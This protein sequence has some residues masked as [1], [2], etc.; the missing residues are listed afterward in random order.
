MP[1]R[2]WMR[3][4][5]KAVLA[6]QILGFCIFTAAFFLPACRDFGADAASADTFMG[7]ECA[8]TT[9]ALAVEPDTFDSPLFLAFMSGWIN[10]LVLGYLTTG[11]VPRLTKVHRPIAA[12]IL[13]C[14]LATWVFFA[15]A[16]FTPLIGHV[17]WIAGALLILT[18][19]AAGRG[20]LPASGSGP[21]QLHP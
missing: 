20:Q 15:V 9:A 4:S 3:V 5:R 8:R 17:L 12:L 11:I 18:P 7:W 21:Q 13:V 19:E 6:C 10:P 2:S 1:R 14:I 16:R